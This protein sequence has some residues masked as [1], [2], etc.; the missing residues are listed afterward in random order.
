MRT[1]IW[2]FKNLTRM[3]LGNQRR[4][5]LAQSGILDSLCDCI[6]LP[7]KS[8]CLFY[9]GNNVGQ[10]EILWSTTTVESVMYSWKRFK[11]LTFQ[12]PC[13]L[14]WP[15][16]RFKSSFGIIIKIGVNKCSPPKPVFTLLV[17]VVRASSISRSPVCHGHMG[18]PADMW[19]LDHC[20]PSSESLDLTIKDLR[21][22][23]L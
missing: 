11:I 17:C 6:Y 12:C 18:V 7:L 5:L 3:T 20:S 23:F 22:S 1:I 15:L 16:L 19:K 13:S 10:T 4:R 2:L 21:K 8:F 9:M 14:V